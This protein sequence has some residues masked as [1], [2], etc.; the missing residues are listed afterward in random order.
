MIG[1]HR[2]C[3]GQ[4]RKSP[5]II[6]RPLAA[7]KN[8]SHDKPLPIILFARKC[9]VPHASLPLFFPQTAQTGSVL[10][11]TMSDNELMDVN[12][13]AAATQAPVGKQSSKSFMAWSSKQCMLWKNGGHKNVLIFWIFDNCF[14]LNL[15]AH[16]GGAV[17]SYGLFSARFLSGVSSWLRWKSKWWLFSLVQFPF[18]W[19][20]YPPFSWLSTGQDNHRMQGLAVEGRNGMECFEMMKRRVSAS[21]DISIQCIDIKRSCIFL[22]FKYLHVHE[23]SLHNFRKPLLIPDLSIFISHFSFRLHGWLY[24]W[25]L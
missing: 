21:S 9:N 8:P 2:E 3:Y 4:E 10:L 20:Y 14:Q 16:G 11:S 6:R 22:H 13:T 5:F 15:R 18:H 23:C 24:F 7:A 12:S 19:R 1:K 25:V 17:T